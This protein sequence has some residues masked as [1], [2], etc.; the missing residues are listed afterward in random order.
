MATGTIILPV[1]AFFDSVNP[2]GYSTFNSKPSLLFDDTAD[3]IC[4][5]TFDM[6]ENYASSPVLILKYGMLSATTNEVIVAC[7][8]MAV[9]AGDAAAITTDSYD[10][11]NTSSA[12]TVPAT[13]E[14][15]KEISLAL[16]NNDSVAADDW[17]A[18]KFSR[19]ANNVG[20]DATGDL[21]LISAKLEYTT[22]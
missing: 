18:L 4:H 5:W 16:T 11:V 12:D 9:T 2:C 15:T 7:Q 1:P 8:V 13:I 3:E 21:R 19:D 10:T 17:T 6:P 22:T 14:H 20:D